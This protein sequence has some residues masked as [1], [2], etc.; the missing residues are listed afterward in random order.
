MRYELDELC[1]CGHRYGDHANVTDECLATISDTGE[2]ACEN[3][4][5][6]FDPKE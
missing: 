1:R 4:C 3:G 2:P 5:V 6:G